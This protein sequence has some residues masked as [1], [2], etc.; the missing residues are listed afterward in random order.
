MA[1]GPIP[2]GLMVLH[3]CPDGDN[4]ACVN[5]AH[6]KLGTH[7]DNMDDAVAKGQ[8]A[9]G[10]RH[11]ARVHP[12][13]M[14]SGANHGLRKH[15]EAAARGERHGAAKLT[16]EQVL[17]IRALVARGAAQRAVGQQ[18]GVSQTL[19]GQIARRKVWAHLQEVA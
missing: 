9:S 15:P 4:R 7:Q 13:C 1:F 16:N 8:T 5:P 10:D 14:A 17:A 11:P 12:G 2:P 3:D 18:F 19:V 6:L